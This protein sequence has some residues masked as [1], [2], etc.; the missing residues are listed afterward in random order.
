MEW[1]DVNIK[2]FKNSKYTG[3]SIENNSSGK[4]GK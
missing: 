4:K 1:L 2:I 3:R